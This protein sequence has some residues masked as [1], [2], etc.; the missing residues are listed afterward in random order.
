MDAG[1]C[2]GI[3]GAY[4]RMAWRVPES[5]QFVGRTIQMWYRWRHTNDF[6]KPWLLRHFDQ[7]QFYP[8]NADELRRMREAFPAGKFK[9][10]ITEETS[11]IKSIENFYLKFPR[12]PP[13]SRSASKRPSTRNARRWELTGAADGEAADSPEKD[14]PEPDLEMP[15]GGRAV[16]AHVAA[17]GWKVS[18]CRPESR[19]GRNA[20]HS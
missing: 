14:A 12:K 7:I 10:D 3:G 15:E 20:C 4:L 2:C 6:P 9:L 17:N 18:A 11:V 16:D 13:L 5:D 19:R 1:K 8:V